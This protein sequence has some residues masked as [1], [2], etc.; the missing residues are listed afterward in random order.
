MATPAN[1]VAPADLPRVPGKFGSA[2]QLNGT[3]PA[4]YVQ[5][6]PGI[7]GG[8]TDFTVAGVPPPQ[9]GRR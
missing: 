7:V 9:A 1:W 2:L 3:S 4:Q 8:L 5:L 6:P